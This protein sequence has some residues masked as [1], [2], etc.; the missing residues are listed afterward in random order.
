MGFVILQSAADAHGR[1]G[2][3]LWVDLSARWSGRPGDTLAMRHLQVVVAEPRILLVTCV[4]PFVSCNFLVLHGYSSS[5]GVQAVAECCTSA[6]PRPL[7]GVLL[8]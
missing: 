3:Q 4:A 8:L 1:G 7:R 5:H 2:L 6:R